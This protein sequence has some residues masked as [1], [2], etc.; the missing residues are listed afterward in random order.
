LDLIRKY[1]DKG[2]IAY[3]SEPDSGIYDAMNKGI[4]RAS[5]KYILFLNSDDY[6]CDRTALKKSVALL[7]K[8]HADFSYAEAYVECDGTIICTIL[9]KIEQ[10]F[11]RMPFC[12]QTMLIK[13]DALINLGKFD[14]SFQTAGDY[15]L[16]VRAIL[17]GYKSAHLNMNII[18]FR[19]GGFTDANLELSQQEC[20]KIWG[21]YFPKMEIG[22]HDELGRWWFKFFIPKDELKRIEHCHK[23]VGRIRKVSYKTAGQKL[24]ILKVNYYGHV[25]NIYYLFHIIPLF[26]IKSRLLMREDKYEKKW[27]LLGITL[28]RIKRY[29][30]NLKHYFLGIPVLEIKKL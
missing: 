17:N 15:D 1:A 23:S 22:R 4:I 28:Y 18:V 2:W 10:F 7:E 14:T 24:Q 5:G 12:H 25:K 19:Y 21:K 29:G 3:Y 8:S 30:N 26:K 6:F 11:V 20:L 27:S 9:S 16:I 13:R